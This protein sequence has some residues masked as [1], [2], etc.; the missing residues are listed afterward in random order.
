MHSFKIRSIRSLLALAVFAGVLAGNSAAL[1]KDRAPEVPADIKVP[2]GNKMYYHG[3]AVGVQTYTWD[4]VSWGASVPDATL[5]DKHGRAIATHY[6]GP[7]WESKDGSKVAAVVD[8]PRVTIDPN[9]IP[10]LRLKASSHEGRGVF[11]RTTYIHRVN[12]VGGKAPATPGA[13]V[14]EVAE[15]P[16]AADYY[17]Y[18]KI[19]DG[20]DQ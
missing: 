10:W 5:Y 14:G 17:F 16:Y 4:G 6:V 15:V 11:A 1:A 7:T 8:A 19:A 2:A 3:Y 13:F 20:A 12:T 9:A 18:R